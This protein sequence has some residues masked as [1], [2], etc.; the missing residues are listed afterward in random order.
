MPGVPTRECS[1]GFAVPVQPVRVPELSHISDVS[2]NGPA[3]VSA[4]ANGDLLC[5]VKRLLVCP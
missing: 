2:S 1:V 4:M 3:G 5:W